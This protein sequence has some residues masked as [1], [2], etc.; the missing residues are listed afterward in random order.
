MYS[1]YFMNPSGF[2][3]EIGWGARSSTHQSEYYQRD[4]F[5][6]TTRW[7]VLSRRT[8]SRCEKQN[9]ALKPAQFGSVLRAV[10]LGDAHHRRIVNA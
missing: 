1:F 9:P 4:I 10:S 6:G 2:M 5:P 8:W 3:S 7:P